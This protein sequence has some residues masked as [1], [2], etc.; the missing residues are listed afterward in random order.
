M[1]A[2]PFTLFGDLDAMCDRVLGEVGERAG[3]HGREALGD[4]DFLPLDLETRALVPPPP[5]SAARALGQG[6]HEARPG[7]APRA[8]RRDDA[9]SPPRSLARRHELLEIGAAHRRCSSTPRPIGDAS[10]NNRSASSTSSEARARA[11]RALAPSARTGVS[12]PKRGSGLAQHD[13][14]GLRLVGRIVETEHPGLTPQ[15]VNDAETLGEIGTR[16]LTFPPTSSAA[17]ASLRREASRKRTNSCP[18][19]ETRRPHRRHLARVTLTLGGDLAA[20][21]AP[22]PSRRWR[23]SMTRCTRPPSAIGRNSGAI[24][25]SPP[26]RAGAPTVERT[27]SPRR[28][29]RETPRKRGGENLRRRGA[30]RPNPQPPGRAA[31]ARGDA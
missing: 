20:R 24:R 8:A 5:P 14:R 7:C 23:R 29:A 4:E 21:V 27:L 25:R 1:L 11:P 3:E 18:P 31:P 15:G 17:R 19:A 12:I 9:I 13:L 30:R 6:R 10:T 26:R 22:C 2:R 28:R 16:R